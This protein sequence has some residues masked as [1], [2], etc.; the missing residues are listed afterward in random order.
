MG[1][2]KKGGHALIETIIGTAAEYVANLGVDAA[3]EKFKDKIDEQK[4][5]AALSEY[6]EH[7]RKYNEMCSLA[8]EIDFRGLVEYIRADLLDE[9]GTRIFDP[10]RKNRGLARQY[11]VDKA[12]V[13]AR[14]ETDAAKYRVS[15]SISICL[16][17]IHEF[18]AKDIKHKDYILASKIV[19][20]VGEEIGETKDE[21]L[22]AVKSEAQSIMNTIADGSLFSINKV[23]QLVQEGKIE[24]VSG[25]ITTV[26]RHSSLEHPLYPDY[27]YDY[28]KGHMISVPLTEKGRQ[29][30]PQRYKFT[31]A[32]KIG[33]QYYN[34]PN[35]DPTDYAYRHQLPIVMKVTKAVRYLGDVIDPAQGDIDKVVELRANPPKFPPAFACA[36]KVGEHTYFEYILL[37]VREIL[38]DGKIVLNNEEQ[39]SH[40]RFGLVINPQ[41]P[42]KPDFKISIKDADNKA[43]LNYTKF[44]KA[45]K[46]E[47]DIHIYVL[48]AEEDLIAGRINDFDLHTGFTSIDEEIDFLERLCSIEDYFGVVLK[49]EGNIS[50]NEYKVVMMIS[51]LVR[52]DEVKGTW[53]GASFTGTL[54]QHF[55]EEFL[56]MKDIEHEFSYVGTHGVDLFGAQFEFRFMRILKE[57]RFEDIERLR[58]KVEVLDDGD[59]VKFTL[60]PGSDNTSIETLHIP[61]KFEVPA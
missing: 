40:I 30:Y 2:D 25:G 18:Y 1:E 23:V 35:G 56:G 38:D 14:A 15:K 37:R 33:G 53:N 21:I 7:Q 34:D 58:K 31:G 32:V 51:D 61:E 39:E 60:I 9:V 8:E 46:E 48:E 5:K 28:E 57:A 44:M 11:I 27:G 10:N 59:S 13:H 22:E 19:D 26:L 52:Q 41:Q 6:I 42:D 4:L 54:D 3:K 29:L 17:I 49:P 12:C 24:Q 50:I 16:D 20:A 45:L 55:R 47:K 36:I 43:C